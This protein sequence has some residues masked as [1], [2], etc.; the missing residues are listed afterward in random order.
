MKTRGHFLIQGLKDCNVKDFVSVY[1]IFLC[2]VYSES[3]HASVKISLGDRQLIGKFERNGVAAFLGVPY[4]KPPIGELRWHAPEPL[5]LSTEPI[6]A[7]KFAPAC[8][9]TGSGLGWYHRMMQRVGVNPLLMSAPAYSEDCLYLN[10]WTNLTASAL[11][12]VL[13][14][15]HG[16]SNTGG[17]SYEPNYIG[18][19]LASRDLVVVTLAYRLGIFGWLSHPDMPVQ[20]LGLYDLA[21]GLDWVTNHIHAFGGDPT[22]ITLFGESAGAANALNLAISP[23][24]S[25]RIGQVIHSSSS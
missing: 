20:N 4:A 6:D 25:H 3:G 22:R 23:L 7:T 21:S 19:A 15:I 5:T 24:N 14:F 16:G 13:I 9:Q 2:L 11:K 18:S 17:W 8:M 10:I 1:V 12:P